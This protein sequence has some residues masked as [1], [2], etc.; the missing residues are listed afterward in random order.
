MTALLIQKVKKL[1]RY[2]GIQEHEVHTDLKKIRKLV[3][4]AL[5]DIKLYQS[6]MHYKLKLLM[7]A[8][9]SGDREQTHSHTGC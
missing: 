7:S 3:S 2:R 6:R 5:T 4:I 8:V 1:P 9:E